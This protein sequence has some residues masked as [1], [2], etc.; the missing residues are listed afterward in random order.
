MSDRKKIEINVEDAVV[1]EENP[2]QDV[3]VSIK[4][5]EPSRRRNST[6]EE[7]KNPERS[8]L[9]MS[10][11]RKKRNSSRSNLVVTTLKR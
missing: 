2:A 3:E 5:K 10:R 8:F 1:K 7:R 4:K 9:S 6:I 11:N